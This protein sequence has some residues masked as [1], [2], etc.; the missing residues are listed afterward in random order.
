MPSPGKRRFFEQGCRVL[1]LAALGTL[2][3]RAWRPPM[4]GERPVVTRSTASIPS[5]LARATRAPLAAL[6]LTIDSLPG[7]RDR[8][9]ARAVAATGTV[10]RW[11]RARD[12]RPDVDSLHAW[13][14]LATALEPIADPSGRVRLVALGPPGSSLAIGDQAGSVDSTKL[15]RTG[16][17][18]LDAML[19]GLVTARIPGG[20]SSSARRDSLVVRPVLVLADAG[21]EGKFI[22]A[23]LEEAGWRVDARFAVAPQVSVRQGRDV[24]IDTA[25]YSAVIAVDA[26]VVPRAASI[27]RF[28]RDGGG[29]I[30]G[31][32]AAS[33]PSL[34][35]ILPARGAAAVSPT[36]GAVVS[37][38]PRRGLDGVELTLARNGA[39]VLD[40]TAGRVRVA[41]ARVG[42]GRVLV[43]GYDDTWRWR[44]EGGAD[45]PRLHRAWWSAM[46]ASVVRAPLVALEGTPD[47]DETPFASLVASLGMP[48]DAPRAAR[49]PLSSTAW[50]PVLFALV[51]GALLTEWTSRRFRGAR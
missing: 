10:V 20:V 38:E 44:M 34:V 32:A 19:D 40:R 17:R 3:W 48:D 33:L 28:V 16:T 26:S 49:P 22:V 46:A 11:R 8:A 30:V 6:D 25:H 24:P 14:P 39:L 9:W 12:L 13:A 4:S 23:A 42:V 2:I 51:L 1:A 47:V 29:L 36:L 37:E 5:A 27:V 31:G 21:W 7:P 18:T 50:E 45:A 15:S 35:G 43:L 41:A